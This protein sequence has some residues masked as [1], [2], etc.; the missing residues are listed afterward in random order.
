MAQ[1]KSII[2]VPGVSSTQIV[3]KINTSAQEELVYNNGVYV[4]KSFLR[5]TL[6]MSVVRL[7]KKDDK[8][9]IFDKETTLLERIIMKIVDNLTNVSYASSEDPFT[10]YNFYSESENGYFAKSEDG[11]ISAYIDSEFKTAMDNFT[12][13]SSDKAVTSYQVTSTVLTTGDVNVED[14]SFNGKQLKLYRLK[15]NIFSDYLTKYHTPYIDERNFAPIYTNILNSNLF[16]R[17]KSLLA[18][19]DTKKEYTYLFASWILP[20]LDKPTSSPYD[21]EKSNRSIKSKLGGPLT[22]NDLELYKTISLSSA[23]TKHFYDYFQ[24]TGVNLFDIT[25]QY[26]TS[27]KILFMFGM[28]ASPAIIRPPTIGNVL[29]FIPRAGT[30]VFAIK[31]KE[32][33]NTA[34]YGNNTAF[35]FEYK[36]IYGKTNNIYNTLTFGVDDYSVVDDYVFDVYVIESYNYDTLYEQD[37][38]S[39]KMQDSSVFSTETEGDYYVAEIE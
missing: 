37:I 5:K 1:D 12:E 24:F 23:I 20:F 9:Y 15:S 16:L 29:V 26:D 28:G 25:S 3:P 34:V 39:L 6:P 32:L 18:N 21:V 17:L 33:F 38:V 19:K 13:E 36:T 27:E 31:I 14:L 7:L 30:K 2:K 8:I 35:T 11:L 22:Y 4:P 10:S